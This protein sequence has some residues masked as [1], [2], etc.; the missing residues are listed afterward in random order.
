MHLGGRNLGRGRNPRAKWGEEGERIEVWVVY[1]RGR[2]LWARGD[3][4]EIC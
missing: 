4:E 3:G 2:R 1:G